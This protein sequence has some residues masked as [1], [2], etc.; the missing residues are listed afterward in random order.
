MKGV[1]P[2]LEGVLGEKKNYQIDRQPPVAASSVRLKGRQEVTPSEVISFQPVEI[3]R[4]QISRAS[5]S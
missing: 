2:H 1:D 4:R 5:P 3:I